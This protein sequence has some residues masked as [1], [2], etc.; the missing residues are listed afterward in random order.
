MAQGTSKPNYFLAI[1]IT[2][3]EIKRNVRA[4]QEA[5]VARDGSLSST[6][7]AIETLHLTLGLYYLKDGQSVLRCRAALDRFHGRLRAENFVPPRL[8]VRDLGNFCNKVLYAALEENQGLEDLKNDV[9]KSL[10]RDGIRTTEDRFTPHVTLCKIP[11]NS[12]S[13][14]DPASYGG[15]QFTYFGRQTVESIQLCSMQKPKTESG[16]YH[17]DQEIRFQ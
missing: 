9:G 2:V 6:M 8:T 5:V 14:I 1:Q 12:S 7:E 17:I 3:E 13:I 15:L 16:Y 4:V 10:S 11:R